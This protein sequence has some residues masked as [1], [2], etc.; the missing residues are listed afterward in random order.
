MYDVTLKDLFCSQAELTGI[1]VL[2]LVAISRKAPLHPRARLAAN[3]LG[4]MVLV[5]VSTVVV[6][7]VVDRANYIIM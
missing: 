5:Q 6:V 4:T 1:L 3:C 2:A 7:V